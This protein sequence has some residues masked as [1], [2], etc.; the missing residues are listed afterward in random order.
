LLLLENECSNNGFCHPLADSKR[1]NARLD[2]VEALLAEPSI[3]EQFTASI[4]KL[5][6]FERLISRIH[7]QKIKVTDFVCVLDGFERDE[8]NW[9]IYCVH[10]RLEWEKAFERNTAVPASWCWAMNLTPLL[11]PA[12]KTWMTLFK[13][14]GKS[15]R[16]QVGLPGKLF[17]VR[18]ASSFHSS[19]YSYPELL[20]PLSSPFAGAG[21]VNKTT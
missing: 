20:P 4:A 21:S 5:P 19:S 11:I 14:L 2:A 7:A 12:S 17:L 6:D 10:G 1:I 9:S 16:T 18:S 13:K 8:Y 3:T 15:W